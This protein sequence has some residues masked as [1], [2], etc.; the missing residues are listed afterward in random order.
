[1]HG[2]VRAWRAVWAGAAL[3]AAAAVPSAYGA[4]YSYGPEYTVETAAVVVKG[5]STPVLTDANGMTLYYVQSDTATSSSCTGGCAKIWPPLVSASV[6]TVERP[7]PGKLAVV[8]TANG[9]QVSYSGHLLY[10]YSGDSAP[11]QANGQGIA[12]KWWVAAVSVKP[13]GASGWG[14]SPVAPVKNDSDHGGGY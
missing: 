5:V 10:R 8:K 13:A 3:I 2:Q 6:P 9:S 1:M 11:H 12:G 4:G 14:W 7:L